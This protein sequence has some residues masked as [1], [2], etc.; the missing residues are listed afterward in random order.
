MPLQLITAPTA[1]PVALAEAKNYR[2]ID[3]TADDSLVTALI[4]AAREAAETITQNQLVAARYQLILDAFPGPSLMGVPYGKPFGLPPHAILIPKTPVI[5]VVS[6]TYLDYT[7]VS[8][9][10]PSTDYVVDLSTEPARITPVFGKIWPIPLPQIGSVQV[11]FDAG[12]VAP[13]TVNT[14]NNSVAPVGWKT[15]AVNDAVRFSNTGGALPTPLKVL[16]DYYV[17]SVVSPGVYTLSATSGGAALTLGADS[18]QSFLGQVAGRNPGQV[19][20]T[21]KAWMELRIGSTYEN[22]EEVAVIP[23][24]SVQDLPFVDRLLDA[25]KLNIF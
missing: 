5:Q 13:I 14:G 15:L 23:R 11:T 3:D 17:Q 1:E 7:G 19:P 22:R 10:M 18:G 21:I 20:Q 9:T 24:G 6:I 12:Y 2:R 16:T 4:S 8:Q 25:F